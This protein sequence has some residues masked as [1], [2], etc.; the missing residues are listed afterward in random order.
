MR[1]ARQMPRRRIRAASRASRACRVASRDAACVPCHNPRRRAC[2]NPR[3]R[4][5]HIPRRGVC[6]ASRGA[7]CVSRPAARRACRTP[8]HRV[9]V[10][11][12][13]AASVVAA[14]PWLACGSSV[15]DFRARR[16]PRR[17][18][19]RR[20]RAGHQLF[21]LRDLSVRTCRKASYF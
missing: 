2:H 14:A 19:A 21:M 16:P 10:V 12:R 18:R 1:A 4:A 20:R 6:V 9:L 17:R 13:G 11:S 7:A 3:S 5:C 8:Q 15:L